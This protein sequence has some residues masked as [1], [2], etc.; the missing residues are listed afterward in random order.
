MTYKRKKNVSS[1]GMKKGFKTKRKIKDLDEVSC[2]FDLLLFYFAV[3]Q[4]RGFNLSEYFVNCQE[5]RLLR[6]FF[7]YLGLI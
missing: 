7:Y 3:E 2:R 1:H 5:L 6:I 4:S